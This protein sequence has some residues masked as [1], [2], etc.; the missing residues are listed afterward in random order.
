[1]WDVARLRSVSASA[2][3][4]GGSRRSRCFDNR[5]CPD[6]QLTPCGVAAH[7]PPAAFLLLPDLSVACQ[8]I[9]P[10]PRSCRIRASGVDIHEIT[11]DSS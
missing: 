9:Q 11:Q 10:T 2:L 6:W 4:I 5:L 1:V 3:L 7:P 8:A